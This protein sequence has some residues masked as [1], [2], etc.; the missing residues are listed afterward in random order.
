MTPVH[1]VKTE[2][3]LSVLRQFSR[4]GVVAVQETFIDLNQRNEN[5]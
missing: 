1:L 2:Q 5:K 4:S 3:R